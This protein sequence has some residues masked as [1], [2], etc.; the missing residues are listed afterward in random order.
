MH[1]WQ[2]GI[3][4]MSNEPHHV[5]DLVQHKAVGAEGESNTGR[6]PRRQLQDVTSGD[7]PDDAVVSGAK[8]VSGSPVILVAASAILHHMDT[9]HNCRAEDQSS[10]LSGRLAS[11]TRII[12]D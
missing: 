5:T 12:G 6:A 3:A 9:H 4:R 7:F 11:F 8:L 10:L 1:S 2:A